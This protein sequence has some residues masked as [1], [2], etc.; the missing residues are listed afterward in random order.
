MKAYTR[1]PKPL[2]TPSPTIVVEMS[3]E[4]VDEMIRAYLG[5]FGPQSFQYNK[6][7]AV[8]DPVLRSSEHV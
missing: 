6:L 7:A 5:T 4:E 8:L 2:P 3:V 1:L